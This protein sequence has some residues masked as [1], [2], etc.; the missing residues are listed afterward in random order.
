MATPLPS[1]P[2]LPEEVFQQAQNLVQQMQALLQPYMGDLNA[3]QRKGTARL[4]AKTAALIRKG[5]DYGRSH[6]HFLPG[7]FN[8]DVLAGSVT[9]MDLWSALR[10]PF[11]LLNSQVED[12]AIIANADAF[13]KNLAFYN[14]VKSAAKLNAPDAEQIAEDLGQAFVG[15]GPKGA[16]PDSEPE[17][18]G[19]SGKSEG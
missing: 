5:P 11:A 18:P 9:N 2:V 19:G 1:V 12:T 7:L 13:Q 16:A 3:K 15:M 8:A 10:R 4:S 14:S 6:P 17:G